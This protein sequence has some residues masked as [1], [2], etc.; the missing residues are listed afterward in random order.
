[1]NDAPLLLPPPSE[2]FDAVAEMKVTSEII[3]EVGPGISAAAPAP[4]ILETVSPEISRAGLTDRHGRSF[5]EDLHLTDE[6][7]NPIMTADRN[8]KMKPNAKKTVFKAAK[9]KISEIF[10]GNSSKPDIFSKREIPDISEIPEISQ[11]EP[12]I[13]EPG[14]EIPL[15]DHEIPLSDHERDAEEKRRQDEHAEFERSKQAHETLK[16]DRKVERTRS[17][18]RSANFIVNI[19]AGGLGPEM[20]RQKKSQEYEDLIYA[21]AE[22]EEETGHKVDLPPNIAFVLAAGSAV[23]G[24]AQNEPA[25]KERLDAGLDMIRHNALGVLAEKFPFLKPFVGRKETAASDPA[26]VVEVSE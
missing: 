20:V 11:E 26:P 4:E 24:M 5:S 22:W 12:N 18:R 3:A 25:C 21:C 10:K 9:E 7:G 13:A 15:S 23:Y 6:I 1:M 19:S 2:R 8:L 17:A 14:C 16:A